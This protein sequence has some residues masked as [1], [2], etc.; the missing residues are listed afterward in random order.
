MPDLH[1]LPGVWSPVKGY[2]SLVDRLTRLGYQPVSPDPSAPAGN[3]L[4]VPYDWRLSNRYNG[5]RLKTL[6]E[7]ALERWRAR[8][9][10][11]RAAKVSFVCHSMGGLVA[12]WYIAKEGGVEVTRKLITL[13]TPYRGAAK[14]AD[15]LVNGVRRDLGPLA[16]DLT[17]FA[18]SLPSLYQLLPAYAC[19]ENGARTMDALGFLGDASTLPELETARVAD[20]LKFYAELE[21]AEEPLPIAD[22]RHPITGIKQPTCTTLRAT[23]GTLEVLETYADVY[24]AGDGTVPAVS[25]PKGVALDSNVL[26]RIADKHGALQCNKAVLDE[27]VGIV[28][29]KPVI[30]RAGERVD[31]TVNAPELLK[32]GDPLSVAV[33]LPA[34]TRVAVRVTVTPEKGQPK[35]RT[36][37]VTNG[38]A[39]TIFNDLP[40]G[41]YTID[42]T[43]LYPG[44]P[45]NPVSS[46]TLIWPTDTTAQSGSQ[47]V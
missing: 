47:T 42:V 17:L 45:V 27:I 26:K 9:G 5:R 19:I 36:P 23:T 3:L 40:P 15:Q 38:S 8:G 43:G 22:L 37:K 10:K 35:I 29:A 1:V 16:V 34:G 41:A 11:D 7:P 31:P 46:N 2:T 21:A 28:T 44:A 18:R 4:I 32:H 6:V 39:A 12:R 14:A 25:G 30:P 24:T 13:G 20:A 33:T